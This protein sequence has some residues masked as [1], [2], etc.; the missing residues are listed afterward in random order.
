[1]KLV[2]TK[3][4]MEEYYNCVISGLM[5]QCFTPEENQFIKNNFKSGEEVVNFK[6][7]KVLENSLKLKFINS[8]FDY[9]IF[10]IEVK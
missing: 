2:L 7:V 8:L 3:K 10:D 1:M 6:P 5:P 4:Q 9:Y